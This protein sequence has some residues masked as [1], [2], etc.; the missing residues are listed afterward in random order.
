MS[1]PFAPPPG[2]PV[3]RLPTTDGSKKLTY[4]SEDTPE[5]EAVKK[6]DARFFAANPGAT[7][8]VRRTFPWE[9]D[10]PGRWIVVVQITRGARLRVPVTGRHRPPEPFAA[11]TARGLR[12][13]LGGLAQEVASLRERAA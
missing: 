4:V 3:Y 12:E 13:M 11:E 2:T 6:D 1:H 5:L 9:T 8:R 10:L 7:Y